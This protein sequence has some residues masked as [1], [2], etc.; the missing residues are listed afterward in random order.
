MKGHCV[1]GADLL[2]SD[3]VPLL[4]LAAE[5][6]LS[7]HERW[8]G[9]GYPLRQRGEEIPLSGRIVA[10]ADT[11]DA[12]THARPYKRAWSVGDAVAEIEALAGKAFDPDV[13]AA[14]G[15]VLA[16]DAEAAA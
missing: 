3:D 11:F 6:A 14:F 8:D 15:E 7:H 1:I 12:L 10:V 13:V 5:I 9:A 4:N 2:A 16:S